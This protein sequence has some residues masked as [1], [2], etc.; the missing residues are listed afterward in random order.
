MG[1]KCELKATPQ[2]RGVFLEKNNFIVSNYVKVKDIPKNFKLVASVVFIYC[3]VLE[4]PVRVQRG[5]PPVL[6]TL[7]IFTSSLKLMNLKHV[8]HSTNLKFHIVK[9][10]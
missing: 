2:T 4:N 8:F 6:N 3:N 5:P 7:I 10:I 9:Q 1:T